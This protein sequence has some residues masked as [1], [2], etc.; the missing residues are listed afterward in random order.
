M[1]GIAGW[2][3]W[4]RDFGG[5]GEAAHVVR[6]MTRTLAPRGPDAE[7]V[8][9]GGC[10]ALGHSRLAVIDIEG[11]KQPMVRGEVVVV[12][13]GEIYNFKELRAELAGLGW[14]FATRSDTEVLLTAYLQWGVEFASRLVGMY[15]FAIWDQ[16]V[17]RLVLVRDRVGI[18][19]LYYARVGGGFGGGSGSGVVFGSEPKALLAHPGMVAEVD[20][21]GIAELMA[22]PRARTPG[23]G[24]FRGVREVRPGCVVVV[25]EVGLRETS[26][27]RLEA[28][29]DVRD[30]GAGCRDV[31][32]LLDD[33]VRHEVVADVPVGAL[34]SGGIDS[35]VVTALAARELLTGE[36]VAFSVRPPGSGGAGAGA[37]GGSTAGAG[38]G[39]G[40]DVWRPSDDEPFAALVAER[41]GLKHVVAG[42]SVDALVELRDV[43]LAARDLPGWGD[44][45]TTMHVLFQAVR[46]HCKVVLSG[47]AADEVFGGYLWQNDPGYVGHSSF[48]WMYG[49]RQPEVL[50]HEDIRRA[51]EPERYEA[52]RYHE[53][54]GE[55]SYVLGE[56]A[57]RRR[58]REV[59]HLGVTRWL[60]GLLDRQ[61]RMSSALGLE[62]RVPFADH[63]LA[64]YLFNVPG[65]VKGKAMPK[66][67]LREACADLLPRE[68][69]QRPKS[70]Y[71]VSRADAHVERMRELVL[72]M[73]ADADAP[74]F[75]LLDR[76]RVRRAVMADAGGGEALP[77]PIT[78]VTPAIGLSYLLQ[79]NE[80]VGR[81]GVRVRV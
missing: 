36:F 4:E 16:R 6:G 71:P 25:D 70:A 79:V 24:T 68:V 52:D 80:W 34:L 15:A 5:G 78:A 10:A 23:H 46:D 64:E 57:E 62:V 2:V 65:V 41:L 1:C 67:L 66:A 35:S 76:E 56:S 9:V 30:F 73:V 27:W 28:G 81:Y 40:A 29:E 74:V 54:L 44:L 51:I 63:R 75:E 53:A 11:G 37:S 3:D 39:A 61:D 38:G 26:Y 69:V 42:V 32:A 50:L 18:K 77:G 59:F 33:I 48:P 49:R 45:D 55:V 43:G 19:P 22:V 47:E 7:E 31:R 13:S 60:P 20:A 17:R 58:E 72:E 12:F 21:E 8:W 14:S